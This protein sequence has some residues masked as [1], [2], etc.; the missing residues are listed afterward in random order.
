MSAHPTELHSMMAERMAVTGRDPRFAEL[1]RLIRD[2]EKTE[3]YEEAPPT[4]PAAPS[5]RAPR[6]EYEVSA[7][8]QLARDGKSVPQ[9]HD[10]LMIPEITIRTILTRHRIEFR[11]LVRKKV[12][13]EILERIFSLARE[14]FSR[15]EIASETGISKST[16]AKLL[17]AI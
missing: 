2:G 8:I 4:I 6:S 12:T 11:K 1:D 15:R 10:I 13:K 5:K 9:I 7:M 3:D 17:A 14:G 16:V